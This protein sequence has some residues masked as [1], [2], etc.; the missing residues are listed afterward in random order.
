MNTMFRV[1]LSLLLA[2]LFCFQDTN[3]CTIIVP[4][5]RKQFRDSKGV[6]VGKVIKLTNSTYV[7]NES[8]KRDIPKVWWDEAEEFSKITF[9]ITKGWKGNFAK[10]Q[11]FFSINIFSCPCAEIRKFEEGKE[12]LVYAAGKNFVTICDSKEIIFAGTKDE[13]KHLDNFWFRTWARI[14]PF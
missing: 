8:E 1:C 11:D 2:L 13:I 12:Y 6:F 3:A 5:L 4:P 10:Q 7:P 9:E 14:Y